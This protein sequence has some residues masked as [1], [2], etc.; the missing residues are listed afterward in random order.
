M[1]ECKVTLFSSYSIRPTPNTHECTTDEHLF[2]FIHL[3]VTSYSFVVLRDVLEIL[4]NNCVV[5]SGISEWESTK[6]LIYGSLWI[7]C[8]YTEMNMT[9]MKRTYMKALNVFDV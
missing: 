5:V 8:T 6:C 2:H 3:V 9:V 7:Y 1:H 4:N